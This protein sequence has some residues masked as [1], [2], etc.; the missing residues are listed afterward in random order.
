MMTTMI[1]M[2]TYAPVWVTY[3]RMSDQNLL[4]LSHREQLSGLS[5]QGL[6][7]RHELRRLANRQEAQLRHK[8]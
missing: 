4:G 7:E 2:Y 5:G 3:E 1:S 8:M 6:E